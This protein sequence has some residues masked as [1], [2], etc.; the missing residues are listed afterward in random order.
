[1]RDLQMAVDVL[2]LPG[3]ISENPTL[4]ARVLTGEHRS[5]TLGL[6]LLLREHAF[7]PLSVPY[8]DLVKGLVA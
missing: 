6:L 3:I 8:F 2:E 7:D 4:R 5:G 1:M